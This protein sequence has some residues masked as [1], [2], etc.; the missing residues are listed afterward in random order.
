M[1]IVSVTPSTL[2]RID[3][4]PERELRRG[5]DRQPADGAEGQQAEEAVEHLH[6]REA[7]AAARDL[8]GQLQEGDERA[9]EGDGA[10]QPRKAGRDGHLQPGRLRGHECRPGHEHGGRAAEAVEQR[11]HLRHLRHLHAIGGDGADSRADQGADQDPRVT[12]AVGEQR[13]DHRQEHAPGADDVAA[14][15]GARVCHAL[16]ADDEQHRGHEVGQVDPAE[17]DQ[18][19]DHALTPSSS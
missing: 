17:V 5:I 13:H 4:D 3:H 8:L 19:R 12:E 9:G 6:A 14:H 18:V 7:E 11:H 1:G 15:G 2:D 10:D 16:D